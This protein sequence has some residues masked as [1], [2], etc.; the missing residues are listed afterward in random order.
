M[1]I[2]IKKTVAGGFPIEQVVRNKTVK[3]PK[4]LGFRYRK[5]Y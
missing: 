3:Y 2:A 4:T 1:A 5:Y